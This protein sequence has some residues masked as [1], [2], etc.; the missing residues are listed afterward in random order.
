M[1]I[2]HGAIP[3]KCSTT[4]SDWLDDFEKAPPGGHMDADAMRANQAAVHR[5]APQLVC[6]KSA[7][8]RRR[9]GCTMQMCV[10]LSPLSSLACFCPP[11]YLRNSDESDLQNGNNRVHMFALVLAD[12]APECGAPAV[13]SQSTMLISE[14]QLEQVL[15]I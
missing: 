9:D 6:L 12:N 4:K 5:G 15:L 7:K 2:N 13:A 10:I 3:R 1:N 8:V 11:L 14:V